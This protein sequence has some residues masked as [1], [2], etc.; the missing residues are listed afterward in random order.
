MIEPDGQVR[1]RDNFGGFHKTPK[2]KHGRKRDSQ[3]LGNV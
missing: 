3:A 1:L 2:I